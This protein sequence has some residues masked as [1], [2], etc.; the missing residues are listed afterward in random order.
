MFDR[1]YSITSNFENVFRLFRY[2]LN[3][4]IYSLL[5]LL[6]IEYTGLDMSKILLKA[7]VQPR[8]PY[9]KVAP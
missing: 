3:C 1:L 5:V 6:Y 9:R 4:I 7:L 8:A 2:R